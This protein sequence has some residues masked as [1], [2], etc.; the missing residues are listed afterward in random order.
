MENSE[1]GPSGY[2]GQQGHDGSFLR[3]ACVIQKRSLA[4]IM[5]SYWID[6]TP[7]WRRI[8]RRRNDRIGDVK[9]SLP[10]G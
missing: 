3:C 8:W 5:L 9:S 7:I 1:E 10:T 4:H 6:S 2:V